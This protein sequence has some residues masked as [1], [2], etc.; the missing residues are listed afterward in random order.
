MDKDTLFN[1][2]RETYGVEPDY[3]WFDDNAVVRHRS[4][5]KWFGLVMTIPSSKVGLPTNE[6][7]DVLNIK[8]EPILISSLH[9]QK[10]FYPAYHMNKTSWI[11]IDINSVAEYEIKMLLDMSYELTRKVKK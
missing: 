8:L 10:G 1:W 11:T 2:I 3:P 5:K 6:N 7:I 4:N 9:H